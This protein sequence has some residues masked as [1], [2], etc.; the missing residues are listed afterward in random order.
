MSLAKLKRTFWLLDI[1]I[2]DILA[3]SVLVYVFSQKIS[4]WSMVK[5]LSY[6]VFNKKYPPNTNKILKPNLT[7]WVA[8][9]KVVPV[10]TCTSKLHSNSFFC[11]CK[12]SYLINKSKKCWQWSWR[13]LNRGDHSIYVAKTRPNRVG[14][15]LKIEIISS[16]F[17]SRMQ[18]CFDPNFVS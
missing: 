10:F 16:N 5:F 18:N 3:Q 6:K 1:F 15:R 2:F 7:N 8:S 11:T 9:P 13:L 12:W 17:F 14:K 4:G